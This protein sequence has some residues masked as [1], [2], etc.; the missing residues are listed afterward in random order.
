[1]EKRLQIYEFETSLSNNL[2]YEFIG[3]QTSGIHNFYYNNINNL[4][5][6]YINANGFGDIKQSI[7]LYNL[8]YKYDIVFISESWYIN[9]E[10]IIHNTNFVCSTPL[11][12]KNG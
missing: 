10:N 11:K 6:L 7:T 4:N 1:M 8:V 9:H 3:N 2:N 5:I 12:K